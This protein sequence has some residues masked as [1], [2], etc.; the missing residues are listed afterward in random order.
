MVTHGGH[1][2]QGAGGSGEGGWIWIWT[3]R[4]ADEGGQGLGVG[5]LTAVGGAAGKLPAQKAVTKAQPNTLSH[6]NVPAEG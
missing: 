1:E 6:W 3:E 5:G 4:W 2:V